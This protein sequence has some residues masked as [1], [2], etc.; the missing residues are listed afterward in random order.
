MLLGAFFVLFQGV[1]WVALLREGLT[2]TS[3]THGAFFYLIIGTH[4]LHAVVALGSSP[5]V[6]AAAARRGS[7]SAA[8][9]RRRSS[10]TSWSACGRSSTP[11]VPVSA[12]RRL[13]FLALAALLALLPR[14]ALACAVCLSGREDDNQRAF[15]A[16]TILLSTLP[17]A[18]IGGMAWYIRRRARE[19][20][21]REAA[22]HEGAPAS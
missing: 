20:A 4:A 5:T 13:A 10:G 16:G 2:L 21:A 14:A 9:R 22:A 11:G 7:R 6:G 19:I 15:L 1:E 12:L 17:V 8:R 3:S 18:L